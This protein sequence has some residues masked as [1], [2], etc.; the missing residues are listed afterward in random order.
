MIGGV[1][2][3]AHGAIC[4]VLLGPVLAM[5]REYAPD[6][7]RLHEVCALIAAELGGKAGDA[8]QVLAD[9]AR[10]CGLPGLVA[11]GLEPAQHPAVAEASLA[12]SSMKGNPFAPEPAQLCD[13]MR[14]AG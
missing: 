12:S 13:I 8:P 4:G 1:T 3:A 2:P 5:N 7:A 9:W 14:I 11:Q 6:P 10:G